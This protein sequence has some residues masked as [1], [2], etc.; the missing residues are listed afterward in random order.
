MSETVLRQ[1]ET[2][3]E[4]SGDMRFSTVTGLLNE[5]LAMF[6]GRQILEVDLEAVARV[7]SAGLA[8]LIEW[9]RRGMKNNT[10]VQFVSMPDQM[11]EIARMSGLETIL[12][13]V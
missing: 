1:T 12:R 8:L 5:S 10:E 9:V 13:S 4:V 3:F 11:K 7:D 2:G 6:E